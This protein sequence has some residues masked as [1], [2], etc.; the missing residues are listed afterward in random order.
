MRMNCFLFFKAL[1]PFVNLEISVSSWRRCTCAWSH[2]ILLFAFCLMEFMYSL[3]YNSNSN[4]TS[5]H[6]LSSYLTPVSILRT[7]RLLFYSDFTPMLKNYLKNKNTHWLLSGMVC[8]SM[9]LLILFYKTTFLLG[10]VITPVSAD[11][12]SLGHAALGALAGM[13]C[14]PVQAHN[15][16]NILFILHI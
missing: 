5:L 13:Y 7:Y 15:L 14:F 2:K 8:P 4:D 3:N 11:S 16:S 12:S 6:V 1:N 9:Y 10:T